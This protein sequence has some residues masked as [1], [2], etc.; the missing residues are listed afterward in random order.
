MA[1]KAF[2]DF[3]VGELFDGSYRRTMTE[4]ELV[5]V[6]HLAGLRTALF[7]DEEWCRKNVPD[8]QRRFPGFLG[9]GVANAMCE[10]YVGH[11]H[12]GVRRL[13][14]V[15]FHGSFKP[16]DTL[17][18]KGSV[19]QKDAGSHPDTGTVTFNIRLYNQAEQPVVEFEPVFTMPKRR[20]PS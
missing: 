19:V 16:G 5:A 1:N 18:A 8:G 13:E 17:H 4:A 9:I 7:I 11:G 6:V 15:V 3:K 14:R 20:G 10:D 12:F 2:D